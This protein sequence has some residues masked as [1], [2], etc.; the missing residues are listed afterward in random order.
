MLTAAR[1]YQK[2]IGGDVCTPE[3]DQALDALALGVTRVINSDL[4]TQIFVE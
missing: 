1:L 2:Q 4:R 3:T